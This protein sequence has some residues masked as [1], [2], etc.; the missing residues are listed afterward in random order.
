MSQR[1]LTILQLNRTPD[2]QR[3]EQAYLASRKRYQRLTRNGP[4]KFYR[5]KLLAETINAYRILRD[6][7]T[8]P[9]TN[10]T[11]SIRARYARKYHSPPRTKAQIEDDFCREVIYRLEGDLIRFDSRREL[12]QLAHD[13]GIAVFRANMLIAQ[14]VESVRTH[15]AFDSPIKDVAFRPRRKFHLRT[16]LYIAVAAALMI[17]LLLVGWLS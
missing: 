7:R 1:A 5:H 9:T 6:P 15:G 10:A 14:I 11:P 12:L 16:A 8:P 13:E 17:D 2:P 3:L 4:L